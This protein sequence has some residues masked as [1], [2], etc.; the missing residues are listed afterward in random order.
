MFKKKVEEDDEEEVE[1]EVG[2]IKNIKFLL[3][4]LD[5]FERRSE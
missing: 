3:Y 2:S 5:S 1:E 4:L